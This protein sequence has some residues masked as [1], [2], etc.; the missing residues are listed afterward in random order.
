MLK[1]IGIMK[2]FI[3]FYCCFNVIDLCGNS[4]IKIIKESFFI[5]N[6]GQWI[7]EVKFLSSLPGCNIWVTDNDIVFDYYQ[8]DC[9]PEPKCFTK[10]NHDLDFKDK[11]KN[12]QKRAVL[13][14]VIK[15]HFENSNFNINGRNISGCNKL[16]SYNNYLIGSDISKWVTNVSH[17]REVKIDNIYDGIDMRLYFQQNQFRYDFI[18]HPGADMSEIKIYFDGADSVWLNNDKVFL[19]SI[20]GNIEHKDLLSYQFLLNQKKDIPTQILIKNNLLTFDAKDYDRASDLIIDPLVFST[21]IHGYR[22]D[23]PNS[24]T[25]DVNNNVYIT[26]QTT[27]KDYPVTENAYKTKYGYTYIKNYAFFSVLTSDGS[28]LVYSSFFGSDSIDGG[29]NSKKIIVQN[30]K[31]NII[32][33]TYSYKTDFDDFPTTPNA[34]QKRL[35][36]ISHGNYNIFITQ[37]DSSGTEI[38]NSTLFGCDTNVNAPGTFELFDSYL[39][40]DGYYYVLGYIRPADSN[41]IDFPIATRAYQKKLSGQTDIFITKFNPDLSG[42]VFSSFF[43]G[44]SW[45]SPSSMIIDKDKNIYVAGV[46][47]SKDFP[48]STNAYQKKIN[49][50]ID[51]PVSGFISKLDSNCEKLL[52]S[53][54]FGNP[55]RGMSINKIK[56]DTEGNPYIAGT[57]AQEDFPTTP[58]AYQ[59]K[60]FGDGML[61]ISKFNKDCSALVSS[62][63]LGGRWASDCHDMILDSLNNVFVIGNTWTDDFPLTKDAIQTQNNGTN[64]DIG[65]FGDA[66]ISKMNPDLSKL[67]FSTYLG[68]TAWEEG[69]LIDID[70]AGSIIIAGATNSLDFPT[71]PN[72]YEPIGLPNHEYVDG[73]VFVAKLDIIT[74]INENE[75]QSDLT[76]L[77]KPN[78][79][80]NQLQII[81]NKFDKIQILSVLGLK[82]LETEWQEII[83]VSVLTPGIYFI[84]I[85]NVTEKFLKL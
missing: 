70:E 62:T 83:D 3:I 76:L 32:G 79:V 26:G 34:Y 84:K 12:L 31:I 35:K 1:K 19:S 6:K 5:E 16:N 44:S 39:D 15:M 52:F 30:S 45:D 67:L 25:H 2:L 51:F 47:E 58:N 33:Y 75:E 74:D 27:S 4:Q 20:F 68:G 55:N 7:P 29:I 18:V 22:D 13:S 60:Y 9:S 11:G 28:S 66:F 56:Q 73:D 53:T 69:S 21:Y 59:R 85:G 43:G 72:S 10:I 77:L 54:Y 24:I 50:N 40:A 63:L 8:N 17:Y 61:F 42:I 49:T 36:G 14:Q 37:F 64:L 48:I 81:T 41:L 78:P 46:T 23:H 71:T 65:A 80:T 57:T 82:V 38:I